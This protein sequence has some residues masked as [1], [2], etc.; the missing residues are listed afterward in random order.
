MTKARDFAD[1]AGAVS[2]GKIA[3]S[4]VN[5]SF[6]NISDTGTTG[7]KVA[8]GTTAQRGST[9]GQFRYNSTTGK[10]EGRNASSFVTIEATPIV[11]SVNVNNMTQKQINDG[12]DL[13]I[14]GSNFAS[15]DI[16]KFV[17]NDNTE[18]V[19][20]TTTVNSATQ[21]TARITSTIDAAKEPYAVAITSAGGLTGRLDSAFNIDS[22]PTWTTASGNLGTLKEGD[23]ANITIAATDSEGDTVSYAETGGT[24]L[25]GAGFSLNS[26]TGV[27]SGT[28]PNVS[29]SATYSFNARATSGTNFT[30]RTFNIIVVDPPSGGNNT[31][32][33]SYGGI[34][35]KLHKFTANGTFTL[36]GSQALD[37]FMI[38]GGGG[39]GQHSGAGGGAGG[40]VWLTN[41]TIAAGTHS[42][43]IGSGGQN[44]STGNA[45]SG[46]FGAKGTDTTAFSKTAMG[47][48]G[49]GYQGQT[50]TSITNGGCGGGASRNQ[51]S[52]AAGSSIQNSTYGYGQGFGGAYTGANNG[53]NNY[54]AYAGGGTGQAGQIRTG[55][56]GASDFINST[57]ETTAFLL[58]AVAGTDAS[59]NAT[60]GSS[61]GTLY[62]GG[63]GGG[64]DQDNISTYF[65]GGKGGGGRGNSNNNSPTGGMVNTGSGSGG[66]SYNNNTAYT[67]LYG[68]SGLVI[69]RY[70]A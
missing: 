68:G 3:S 12:F 54:A 65:S 49:G 23:S 47:G 6:E 20:P 45:S 24:V 43:V 27:I 28:A 10:F 16:A 36:N 48:G 32:T 17:A 70:V 39:G 59:N 37:L 50:N 9:Q 51:G 55:G 44:A 15:G 66:Q 13:V 46:T 1:I 53:A 62:I 11:S 18:F 64:S 67:N 4:D 34:S 35:Y 25:S 52:S 42:I 60:T 31:Y 14:T 38:G 26:S 2:G 8:V 56:D 29:N 22:A 61:S 21:I 19:S 57:A 69:I 63:G 41:Q 30:D 40:L 58:A 33:Y 5:V 7:T